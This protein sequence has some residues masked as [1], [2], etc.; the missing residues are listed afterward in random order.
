MVC[1][2]NNNNNNN[3]TKNGTNNA[4]TA[5]TGKI[6]STTTRTWTTMVGRVT[7]DGRQGMSPTK[8]PV[9]HLPHL[10][11]N[12]IPHPGPTNVPSESTSILQQQIYPGWESYLLVSTSMANHSHSLPDFIHTPFQPPPWPIISVCTTRTLQA[13]KMLIFWTILHKF[14]KQTKF[15]FDP[16]TPSLHIHH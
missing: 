16:H 5:T 10:Q 3:N 6:M 11:P 15:S 14:L 7:A 4:A 8:I 12:F 9:I 1:N 13:I 2:N